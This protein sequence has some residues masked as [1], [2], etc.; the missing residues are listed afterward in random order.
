MA[1]DKKAKVKTRAVLRRALK[2]DDPFK[3]I[4]RIVIT[5]KAIE[6]IQRENK[7]TLIVD[8]RANKPTIKRVVE[9]LFDVE[10]EKVNTMITPEGEKKAI[11]KLAKDYSAIEIASNLGIL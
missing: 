2:I 1:K 10:V 11:V 6:L 8:R 9:N 3:V 4:K 5:E 7:L